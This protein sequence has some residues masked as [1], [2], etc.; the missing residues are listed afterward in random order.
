MYVAPLTGT[1]GAYIPWKNAAVAAVAADNA[2][3][4]AGSHKLKLIICDAG[5]NANTVQACGRQAVQ[6]KV[7]GAV[8]YSS[9]V[10][11]MEPFF[12]MAGIPVMD[13][14]TDPVMLKS[15]ISYDVADPGETAEYGQVAMAKRLGCKKLVLARAYPLPPA[16]EAAFVAAFEKAAKSGGLQ[17]GAV[18]PPPGTPD[19]SSYIATALKI[20]PDCM[21]IEALGSDFVTLAKAAYA[22]DPSLKILTNIGYIE[23]T[24]ITSL[25]AEASK[26]YTLSN[27]YP[28]SKS[29]SAVKQFVSNINKYSPKPTALDSNSAISYAGVNALAAAI[30]RTTGPVTPASVVKSLQSMGSFDPGI[31][32]AVNF[33][34]PLASPSGTRIFAPYAIEVRFVKG[35]ATA[36]GGFFNIYNSHS[37]PA[38]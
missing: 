10:A 3:G 33:A 24:T 38:P 15:P 27:S 28:A 17:T 36:V 30:K 7:V 25:G 21:T 12:R 4:A 29:T 5:T 13:I 31:M 23:P 37:V 6:D 35:V 9:D 16:A 22:A 2:S 32:P 1:S 14:L 11:P 26:L 20:H 18:S 19:M 8:N 34:K